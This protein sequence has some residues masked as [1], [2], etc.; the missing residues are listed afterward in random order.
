MYEG[1]LAFRLKLG[2]GALAIAAGGGETRIAR[3]MA[4]AFDCGVY[5]KTA[6]ASES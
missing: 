1:Q 2:I 4:L 3:C 5:L 6:R